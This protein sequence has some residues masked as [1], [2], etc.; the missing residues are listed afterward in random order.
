ML[1]DIPH[2]V[3]LRIMSYTNV[4]D[5][6]ALRQVC[7]SLLAASY[8]RILWIQALRSLCAEKNIFL[9]SF[10]ISEMTLPQLEH[11][12]TAGLRF[13][14]RMRREFTSSP[15]SGTLRPFSTRILSSA[16]SA[17]ECFKNT[18]LVPGG[19]FLL[20]SCGKNVRIWDV[21]F[22]SGVVVN[23]YP[24]ASTDV[25][26]AYISR[27]AITQSSTNE[28]EIL[29]LVI[30]RDSPVVGLFLTV[31]RICPS[32]E[33]A[34]FSLLATAP[35]PDGF[36]YLKGFSDSHAAVVTESESVLLWNFRQDTWVR[37]DIFSSVHKITVC[38][39][40]LIALV[41][42]EQRGSIEIMKLPPMK[43]RHLNDE[44]SLETV[45]PIL[46]ITAQPSTYAAAG[47]PP[48]RGAETTTLDSPM[49]FDIHHYDEDDEITIKHYVLTAVENGGKNGL[50]GCLPILVGESPLEQIMVMDAMSS[51]L[52]W[53][54]EETFQMTCINLNEICTSI[55]IFPSVDDAPAQRFSGVLF[56][57]GET[58]DG[59]LD[60]CPFSGRLCL[61]TKAGD[62][63]EV[64]IVDY[65]M[66]S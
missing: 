16:A 52:H 43:P 44:P 61:R 40:N 32:A 26:H 24:I 12:A 7:T 42:D 33:Q 66:P 64:R 49:H 25:G 53:H 56:A 58:E 54:N 8:Q 3:L 46:T 59:E 11:A 50:P 18:I 55:S 27:V 39:N 22:H 65:L 38:N 63:S 21:G 20:T 13:L 37:C 10:P 19:R 28:N 60:I 4:L 6:I 62:G 41:S 23:P 57:G 31:Y 45:S 2:D 30:S 35:V 47:R 48:F 36:P 14:A 1:K 34:Q 51:C 15:F 5:I 17:T 29:V 9:P